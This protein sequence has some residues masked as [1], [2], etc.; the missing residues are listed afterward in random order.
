MS[1]RDVVKKNPIALNPSLIPTSYI[2]EHVNELLM[3]E[4]IATF[5]VNH[6]H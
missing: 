5:E 4:I 6:L 3:V 1:L 2:V